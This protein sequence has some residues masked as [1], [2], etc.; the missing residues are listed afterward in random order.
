LDFL[1]A[2]TG[3]KAT[4]FSS[5]RILT[6]SLE[7]EY[8]LNRGRNNPEEVFPIPVGLFSTPN[9]EIISPKDYLL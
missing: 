6:G 2:I 4:F 7:A 3:Q 8:I 5:A 1:I 9:M